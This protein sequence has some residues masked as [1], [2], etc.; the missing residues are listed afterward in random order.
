MEV[1]LAPNR[2]GVE[3]EDDAVV[4]AVVLVGLF[5]IKENAGLGA[6]AESVALCPNVKECFEA[7][8]ADVSVLSAGLPKLNAGGG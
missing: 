4:E 1:A 6:A 3:V 2:L 8:A 7:S 5:A